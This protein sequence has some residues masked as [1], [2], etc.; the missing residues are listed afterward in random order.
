MLCK[1]ITKKGEK[2][3]R[4]TYSNHGFCH[5][6]FSQYVRF[7]DAKPDECIVC[8][9]EINMNE[10]L[11]CG[12]WVHLE[13]VKKSIKPQC[14]ICCYDLSKYLTQEELQNIRN[15][16]EDVVNDW[17]DDDLER[18]ED[19][20]EFIINIPINVPFDQKVCD[21]CLI[22]QILRCIFQYE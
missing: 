14:P 6:H 8:C 18:W 7:I 2:C 13:C 17:E 9:E 5:M 4:K 19:E 1:G 11:E 12:H 3:K 15:N 22:D 16:A 21:Q 20:V 10:P